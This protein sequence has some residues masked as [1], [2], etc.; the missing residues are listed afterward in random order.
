MNNTLKIILSICIFAKTIQPEN[1]E[2]VS[3]GALEQIEQIELVEGRDYH[4]DDYNNNDDNNDHDN[5]DNGDNEWVWCDEDRPEQKN[6]G[7]PKEIVVPL[8]SVFMILTVI[9][10]PF[11]IRRA[12]F[13]FHLPSL[14]GS[15]KA[16]FPN[17]GNQMKYNTRLELKSATPVFIRKPMTNS[18]SFELMSMKFDRLILRGCSPSLPN[19][20]R[21]ITVCLPYQARNEHYDEED[22]SI[23]RVSNEYKCL[24]IIDEA[25]NV[26]AMSIPSPN[27]IKSWANRRNSLKSKITTNSLG[28]N[29]REHIV[30]WD[31]DTLKLNYQG[32]DVM[33]L[34]GLSSFFMTPLG[35]PFF[36]APAQ[37]SSPMGVAAPIMAAA[38]APYSMNMPAVQPAV[39]HFLITDVFVCNFDSSEGVDYPGCALDSGCGKFMFGNMQKSKWGFQTESQFV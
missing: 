5:G 12:Y 26:L 19:N 28:L 29:F 15:R 36:G 30:S 21:E 38:P 22:Y 11:Q 14:R 9:M 10:L 34:A 3:S 2:T 37:M 32:V 6:C 35:Q 7:P 16:T 8:I 27:P 13:E 17:P 18:I 39:N 1:L 24:R 20:V 23:Y 25:N 33:V 4:S 31:N